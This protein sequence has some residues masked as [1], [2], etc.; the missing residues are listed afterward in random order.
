MSETSKSVENSG[1]MDPRRLQMLE[2]VKKDTPSNLGVFRRAYSSKSKGAAV[3]AFCLECLWMDRQA[4]RACDV[5]NCPLLER[6]AVPAARASCAG[7]TWTCSGSVFG[8]LR[9][10]FSFSSIFLQPNNLQPI[11]LPL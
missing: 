11:H 3:K 5:A 7:L 6:Q 4:I 9:F 1:V 2:Q 8:N 10:D